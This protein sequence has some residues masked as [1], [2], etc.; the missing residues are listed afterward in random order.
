MART[1]VLGHRHRRR[2]SSGPWRTTTTGPRRLHTGLPP[3]YSTTTTGL[4]HR[5]P[6]KT[7]LSSDSFDTSEVDTAVGSGNYLCPAQTSATAP[8]KVSDWKRAMFYRR[9]S[10]DRA[11][12]RR[13]TTTTRAA[14]EYRYLQSDKDA[15]DAELPGKRDA[16]RCRGSRARRYM[17]V[18]FTA[19]APRQPMTQRSTTVPHRRRGQ[20]PEKAKDQKRAESEQTMARPAVEYWKLLRVLERALESVPEERRERFAS[21][22]PLR[23]RSARRSPQGTAD[24]GASRST[25]WTSR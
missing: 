6:V 21:Q 13:S 2:R 15:V 25:E 3:S 10:N 18:E 17:A 16:P 19:K 20:L 22:G 9:N 5:R 4:D 23:C 8:T 1:L 24:V 14:A 12:T 7:T 11:S